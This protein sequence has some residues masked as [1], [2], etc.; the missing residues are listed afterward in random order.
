M[1]EVLNLQQFLPY[2]CN[3]LAEKISVSL[4]KI[5]VDQFGISVAQWRILVTLAQEGELQAKRIGQL[6][7]MDK[8]RVSR[9][10]AILMAKK[11]LHRRS[12]DVD[13]RAAILSLS[14]AGKRLYKRIVPQALA[15]ECALLEP[16]SVGEQQALFRIIGKLER[17]LAQSG[18]ELGEPLPVVGE[19]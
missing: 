6:T 7:N 1:N 2:R 5:Y 19:A 16:L 18:S 8:V 4:S 10:V 3:N 13:S 17:R 11:L 12:C 9:A 14:A 15:W